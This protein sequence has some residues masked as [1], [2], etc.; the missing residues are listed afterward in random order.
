MT[1]CPTSIRSSLL[2][3]A[4][5]L[6][7]AKALA[8]GQV[9]NA[10]Q[11]DGGYRIAG[12]VVSM[13]DGHPLSRARI[14]LKNVK[15]P[16][17]PQ[18]MVTSED[19]KFQF[20]EVPAGKYSLGGAKRGFISASYDEHD[21]LST[22][23][24]TGAG[25]DTETLV[26]RLA[27]EAVITG[28]VLDE[29]GE[30]VRRATVA[31][32]YDDHSG[33]MDQI[34]Q[35][36]G[37]QT[38]DQG[39]YEIA[40]V[41]PGTYFLS[42]SGKPWYAVYPSLETERQ[43]TASIDRSLDVAYPVTY[44]PDVTEADGAMPI[45]VRGGDRVQVDIHLIPVPAL[46]LLLR[47]PD[48][49]PHGMTHPQLQQSAFD[50]STSVQSGGEHMVS[51][52]VMEVTGIP[53]GK[54]S[55]RNS[56]AGPALQ[57]NGIDLSKDGQEIDTSSAEILSSVKVS[58]HLPG[59]SVL[60][61]GLAVGLRSGNRVLAVWQPVDAKGEAE[62]PQVAAGRY[63]VLAVGA[64]K[65]YAVAHISAEGGA[66]SGHTLTVTAGSSIALSLT[67]AGGSVEVLGT[68]K[69]GGK[70]VAGA[71]V[72]LVPK[73]PEVNRDLFRRDQSDLDG[74]FSLRNVVP[75]SYTVVAIEK[76]W[77]LDWSRPNVMAAY[78]KGGRTIEVGD[79]KGRSIN[80]AEAVEV[81]S[82]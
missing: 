29:V 35:L 44:Y 43:A 59:E 81:Q 68:V 42:A 30:P 40:P 45:P 6:L 37:A 70:A 51:P 9:A 46:R 50:G 63:E 20:A 17:K 75:G 73:D 25:V 12:T 23:I 57:V 54:Y 15:D 67:L 3:V 52:G 55:V 47:V 11:G 76:G 19:G 58:V 34:H 74:T 78:L 79:Q 13:V 61:P 26:L 39:T 49:G 31:L 53:A 7:E 80:L 27:P 4:L 77:D 14:S 33:G 2:M 22:A 65:P 82:K 16:Q 38:D 8:A 69:Q 10:S 36:R 64:E 72:V 71:M 60:P 18:S 21:Q 41:T 48:G 56:G 1:A 5:C 62:L 66:V 24:V 28:R 32:Y